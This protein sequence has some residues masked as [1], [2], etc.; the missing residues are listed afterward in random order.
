MN[1]PVP[2][3]R[4]EVAAFAILMEAKLRKNDHKGHWRNCRPSDLYRRMLEEIEELRVVLIEHAM[5]GGRETDIGDEAADVANFAMMV[6]DVC[7][8]LPAAKAERAE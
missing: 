1:D 7:G 5:S 4:P 2:D 3:A 8:A 6:A